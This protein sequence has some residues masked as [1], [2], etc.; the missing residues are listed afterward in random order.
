MIY[1]PHTLVP[2]PVDDIDRAK[3]FYTQQVGFVL[4]HDVRPNP[5]VR[6]VQLTPSGSVC[7]IVLSEGL[8]GLAMPA[9]SLRG[10]HLVVADIG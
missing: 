1:C 10:L 8:V 3:R 4:D 2:V 7:S 5:A 6:M 9:G